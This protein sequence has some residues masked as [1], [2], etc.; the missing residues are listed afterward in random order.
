MIRVRAKTANGESW[1]P[2]T[3]VN[4]VVPISSNSGNLY[5]ASG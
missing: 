2:K 3:K 1:D 4:R 5:A